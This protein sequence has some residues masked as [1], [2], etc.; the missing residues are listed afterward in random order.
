MSFAFFG[1]CQ[2]EGALPSYGERSRVVLAHLGVAL[3]DLPFTC[4]GYPIRSLRRDAFLMSAARNLALAEKAGVPIVTPCKCCFGA[5]KNAERALRGDPSLQDVVAPALASEGLRW[6][7]QTEVHHLLRVLTD[8][9]G[10]ET[11][12]AAVRAPLSDW[13]LAPSYGCH[14]LRPSNVTRFDNPHAP[15]LFENLLETLGAE[16]VDWPRRLAC[17]GHP[18]R[19][20]NAPLSLSLR[21]AK[22]ADAREAGA[23]AICTACTY[24]HLQFGEQEADPSSTDPPALLVTDLLAAALGLA[25][26]PP[27]PARGTHG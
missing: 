26:P 15:T 22:L 17:C 9:V 18:L 8:E 21:R 12:A 24:C 23:D 10:L 27:R 14:A 6:T 19:D 20:R 7:G 5:L 13:R 4:C 1:G 25:D 11:I 3:V 16:V 2:V